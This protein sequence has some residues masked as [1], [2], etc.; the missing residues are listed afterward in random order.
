MSEYSSFQVVDLNEILCRVGDGYKFLLINIYRRFSQA[1]KSR[2]Y[3]NR[4]REPRR[5]PLRYLQVRAEE[6]ECEVRY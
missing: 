6:F 5:K 2:V 4:P 3:S 1:K